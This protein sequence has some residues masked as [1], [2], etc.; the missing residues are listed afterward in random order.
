VGLPFSISHAVRAG[1]LAGA[2]RDP[3]DRMLISQAQS[4][5]LP[6]ISND[7]IFD[8]YHVQRIW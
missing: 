2:H 8:E 6:I 7:R 1:T 5:N 4:E 3:F